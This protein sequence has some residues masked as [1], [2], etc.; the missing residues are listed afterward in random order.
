[1]SPRTVAAAALLAVA[2]TVPVQT[3]G[4][5]SQ[6]TTGAALAGL[7]IYAAFADRDCPD[8]L[9]FGADGGCHSRLL[10]GELRWIEDQELPKLQV[11][12]GLLV[13]GI[14]GAMAAGAW[15][16]S[17]DWDTI[18]TLGAGTLLLLGA[19]DYAPAPGTVYAEFGRRRYSACV[20]GGD[21]IT[22]RCTDAALARR[23]MLWAGV[24]TMGLAAVRWFWP[25]GGALLDLDA[26]PGGVRVSTTFGF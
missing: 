8:W 4:R 19:F 5:T 17:R 2:T 25:G 21:T 14:G 12:G 9:Y 1:M 23:G 13:A 20:R 26:R 10:N 24:G 22:D 7:G 6:A 18:A 3:Q 11:A 15:G 16:P